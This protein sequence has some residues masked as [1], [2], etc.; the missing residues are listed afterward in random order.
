MREWLRPISTVAVGSV[1][2]LAAC[3]PGEAVTVD[4]SS[5]ALAETAEAQSPGAGGNIEQTTTTPAATTTA[6]PTTVATSPLDPQAKPLR[7]CSDAELRMVRGD[8]TASLVDDVDALV[9]QIGFENESGS[10]CSRPSKVEVNIRNS[11]GVE[12]I[13]LGVTYSCPGAKEC[14]VLEAG[15]TV[16]FELTWD[17][18]TFVEGDQSFPRVPPGTYTAMV[19]LGAEQIV[20]EDRKS[21]G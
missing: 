21:V 3:G 10:R 4:A 11:A 15:E 16:S 14:L 12:V 5:G 8:A 18:T 17:K 9:L 19:V 13:T 20:M 7:L 2:F 1:M 6:P